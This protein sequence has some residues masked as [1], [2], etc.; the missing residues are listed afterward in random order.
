MHGRDGG[1]NGGHDPNDPP[2]TTPSGQCDFKV[3]PNQKDYPILRD[4]AKYRFWW[5][6]F[7]TVAYAHGLQRCFDNSYVP[8]NRCKQ[9]CYLCMN[10][11]LYM[12]L[13]FAVQTY[14]G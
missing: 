1:S 14:E 4:D 13:V 11:W 5:D 9:V 6:Q 12:V 2:I 7:W 3:K 10:R 8:H